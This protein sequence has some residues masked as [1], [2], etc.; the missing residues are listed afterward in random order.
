MIEIPN[1]AKDGTKQ[2]ISIYISTLLCYFSSSRQIFA[3]D[4][5]SNYESPERLAI[6]GSCSR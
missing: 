6:T 3:A 5:E 1:A 4:F 2:D